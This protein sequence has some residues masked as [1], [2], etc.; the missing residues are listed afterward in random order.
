MREPRAGGIVCIDHW[1]LRQ[2][3]WWFRYL[4][5][6]WDKSQ[7]LCY[8]RQKKYAGGLRSGEFKITVHVGG[9]R[10]F[11]FSWEQHEHWRAP[12][13]KITCEERRD[14][15]PVTAVIPSAREVGAEALHCLKSPHLC[16]VQYCTYLQSRVFPDRPIV[17][18]MRDH[19]RV[20]TT[21]DKLT[22]PYVG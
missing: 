15:A 3:Y 20:V 18:Y 10:L 21:H 14:D 5:G 17:L 4:T 1:Q 16:I 22:W 2:R 11:S 7:Q 19:W 12:N 8:R 13:C 9:R 6:T